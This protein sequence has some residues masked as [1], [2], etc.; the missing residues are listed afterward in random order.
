MPRTDDAFRRQLAGYSLAT[1]EIYYRMPDA[2]DVLQT[3]VWQ[4]YDIAPRFPELR[5]FL[6]FWSRELEGPIHSVRLAHAALIRPAEFSFTD[7]EL[8]TH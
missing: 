3:F 6:D 8:T 4:D 5:R 1:A 7:H 2:R